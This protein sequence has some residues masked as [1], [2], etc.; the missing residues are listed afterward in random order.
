MTMKPLEETVRRWPSA[1]SKAW[2]TAFLERVRLDPNVISVVAIG[3][4]VRSEVISEDLD[5]IV[6]CQDASALAEK[7][8]IE[9]DLR[10]MNFDGIEEKMKNGHDL[11][12]WA[13]RFGQ[14]LLDNN[15]AWED[16]VR[17]WKSRLPP[18][19]PKVFTERA[20]AMRK[21]M[22]EM[23]DIGDE[24]AVADL[25]VSYLTHQ[26]RACLAKAGVHPQSRPELP[27]QLRKL[28]EFHLAEELDTVLSE[29]ES[30]GASAS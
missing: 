1:R 2:L 18:P 27:R 14:P 28:G 10:K 25:Q 11:V 29:R 19:D 20:K 3:S 5:V 4:S 23:R 22:E 26:A 17:R 12:S 24:N 9:I 6:L 13:V 7:A 16:I 21:R 8:P 15:H 30:G